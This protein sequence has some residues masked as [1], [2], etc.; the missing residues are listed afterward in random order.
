MIGVLHQALSALGL[1]C[2]FGGAVHAEVIARHPNESFEAL[3][4]RL[5]PLDAELATGAVELTLGSLGKAG[6]VLFE[7]AGSL[8]YSGWV[9]V[10][11]GTASTSYEKTVL[12]PLNVAEGRFQIDVK[13]VFAADADG[14]A[15]PELCVLSHYYQNGSGDQAYYATDVFKWDGKRFVLFEAA[16]QASINLKN[17]KQVRARFAQRIKVGKAPHLDVK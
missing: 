8:T 3:A 6:V 15:S 13:S 2:C 1:L 4:K 14:D 11:T 17:A 10:P 9:F 5:V 12:P 7:P 16:T